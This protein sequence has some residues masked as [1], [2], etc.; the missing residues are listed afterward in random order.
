MPPTRANGTFSRMSAALFTVLKASNS[1]TKIS[2]MLTGNDHEQ[3]PHG[4]LL[5]LELAAPGDVVARAAVSD[6]CATA[7]CIS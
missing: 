5:V 2:S 7:F 4:A 3:P 1:S 6:S